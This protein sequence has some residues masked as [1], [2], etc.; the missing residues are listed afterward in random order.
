LSELDAKFLKI[1]SSVERI[2]DLISV[3]T[4]GRCSFLGN[5]SSLVSEC[6]GTDCSNLL[7]LAPLGQGYIY[8]SDLVLKKL[9]FSNGNDLD[10][11]N[12]SKLE[13]QD[14]DKFE[15]CATVVTVLTLTLINMII[16]IILGASRDVSYQQRSCWGSIITLI[17]IAMY[18]INNTAVRIV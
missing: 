13:F 10:G 2:D 17:N 9:W 7:N 18:R 11:L 6:R 3:E 8:A 4:E 15:P 1:S 16:L 12:C 14:L 5:Y